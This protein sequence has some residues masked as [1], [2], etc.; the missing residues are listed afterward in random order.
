MRTLRIDLR[1]DFKGEEQDK[2]FI[3]CVRQAAKHM[4]ATACLL[5]DGRDPEIAIIGDNF[6]EGRY[7]ISL[8]EDLEEV[9][10]EQS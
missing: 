2:L 10:T 6:F 5:S 4:F 9:E 7:E 1:Y 8:A 3:N